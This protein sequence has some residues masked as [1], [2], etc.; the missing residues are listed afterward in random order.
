MMPVKA[1]RSLSI[2]LCPLP[3]GVKGTCGVHSEMPAGT[4]NSDARE[5]RAASSFIILSISSRK[6]DD[7]EKLGVRLVSELLLRSELDKINPR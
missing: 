6:S 4:A 5:L 2:H 3:F 7:S 1:S